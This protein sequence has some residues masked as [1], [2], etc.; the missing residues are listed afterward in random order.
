MTRWTP[1]LLLATA[2]VAGSTG[3]ADSQLTM[4]PDG[5]ENWPFPDNAS[6][7][8]VFVGTDSQFN[9]DVYIVDGADPEYLLKLTTNQTDEWPAEG[10]YD[11]NSP[12]T[13]LA[14][15]APY[16]VPDPAARYVAFVTVQS[17][18]TEPPSG[19]V[20]LA[21]EHMPLRT[22]RS[23]E[24]LQGVVFD[25]TGSY[26]LL[27]I[28]DHLSG[29]TTLQVMDPRLDL[30]DLS[31]CIANE[32]LGPAAVA[33][34]AYEGEGRTPDTVLVTGLQGD[35]GV[36]AV[37]EVPVP[38]GPVTLLTAGLELDAL[39]PTLSANGRYVAV[40]L[41][42]PDANRS[43][44][45]VLD[46]DTAEWS[47]ITADLPPYDYRSARWE[48]SPDQGERLAFLL[49]DTEEDL[50]Q[51]CVA[52]YGEDDVWTVETRDVEDQLLQD[53][54]LSN[55]R[56]KPTGGQLLLDYSL[57]DN[58]SGLNVI[59]LVIYDVDGDTAQRLATDG[60][61]ELAHW[62]HDGGHVLMWDRSVE[63][64]DASGE[65]TPIRIFDQGSGRTDNVL[66]EASDG[67]NEVLYIEYP[68]FLYRNTMWY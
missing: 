17:E 49:N 37:W 13:L 7:G 46:S 63:T 31:E 57:T 2:L 38:D 66:I 25:P 50:T 8:I 34:L 24:G 52:T 36:A 35:P 14:A 64:N 43:D 56:W 58:A 20:S 44:I 32:D 29:D 42:D 65:R 62:S 30:Y 59:E 27:T 33:D 39:D 1:S 16:G 11:E 21:E 4:A 53:R 3:C 22:S 28:V 60:E 68:L 41:Y 23:I 40:Q 26:M 51:V 15:T 19:R 18:P 47:V 9:E 48:P 55:P 45:A 10:E 54:L 12:G 6:P 61:P 5:T 67:T